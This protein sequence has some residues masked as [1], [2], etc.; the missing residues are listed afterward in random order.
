M[1]SKKEWK[2]TTMACLKAL[3][4]ISLMGVKI[5]MNANYIQ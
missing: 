3:I 5:S 1:M 4:D 2:N